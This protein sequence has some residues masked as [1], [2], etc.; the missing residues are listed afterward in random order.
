VVYWTQVAQDRIQKLF[1][2]GNETQGSIKRQ[3]IYCPAE[4]TTSINFSREP[5]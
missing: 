2:C 3:G 1:E 4:I 5:G